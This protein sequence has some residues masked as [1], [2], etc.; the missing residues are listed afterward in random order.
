MSNSLTAFNEAKWT[1]DMQPIFYK[2]NVAI[3]LANTELR[4]YLESGTRVHKPYMS[5][6]IDQDYTKGT[7]ISSFNDLTATDDY[8]DVDTCRLVPF[9]IDDLDKIQNKYDAATEAAQRA[10][11]RLNNRL[12]Q[13]VL[14]NYSSANAYISAQDLGGSGTDSFA[15]TQGNIYNLFAVGAR[16][17]EHANVV[18]GAELTALIGP[19][20]L[21]VLRLAVAGRETGLG[22]TVGENG[23]VGNKFGFKVVVS[24]NVPFSAVLTYTNVATDGDTIKIDDVTFTWEA[25]GT[26]CNAAGEVDLGANADAGYANLVLAINGTTAGTT[27]TYYDVSVADRKKLRDHG[28]VATQSTGDDTVTITGYGDVPIVESTANCVLTSNTQYPLF[29]AGKPIELI[30]QKAPN[31]EFR[32]A[33]KR[34]GR[35]IYAWT[36]YGSGV[37]T[38][39]KDSFLYAKIDTSSWV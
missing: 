4:D 3:A 25:T 21:E 38:N 6:L 1:R 2:E 28:I 20:L 36:N 33:E 39:M 5:D 14:S 19:R 13:K 9:Y 7:D 18:Q 8:L 32:I 12:D 16:K 22:D 24:N 35:Y 26:N 37:W 27:S 11:R 23:V 31:V 10:Q 34:L 30:V 15:V 29:L 17:L